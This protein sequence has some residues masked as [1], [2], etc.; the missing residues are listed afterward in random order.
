MEII[1]AIDIINGKCVRLKQ[2]DYNQ[3]T[4][5][6]ASPLDV[7][8]HFEDIGATRLHIVD[9]DGAK[10]SH[11]VNLNVLEEIAT[12]TK[13][14]VDFGGGIKHE[15]DLQK[16]FDCGAAM[17]T[18]GSVAVTSP[19]IVDEWA[20]R[21][22]ADR[23]I[24]GA[25]TLNGNIMIRGWQDDGGISLHDFISH[26]INI[27]VKH[28]LCTDITRDGMLQGPNIELYQSI[29]QAYPQCELIA[30]GGISSAEDIVHLNKAGIPG[31]VFGRAYYEGH[32]TD[33]DLRNILHSLTLNSSL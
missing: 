9:L 25:D 1:P 6:D 31:V 23:F 14:T 22:G 30:S 24:V 7:A 2:G 8:K 33:E 19:H 4:T 12:H 15:T 29:M 20:D 32:I 21:F 5:Y 17:V 27:G 3:K 10:A 16:A 18:V 26:Y 13:L 28:V 11:V